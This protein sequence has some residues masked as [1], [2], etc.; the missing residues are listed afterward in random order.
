MGWMAICRCWLS[1][2]GGLTFSPLGGGPVL[3]LFFVVRR[4]RHDAVSSVKRT[5]GLQQHRVWSNTLAEPYRLMADGCSDSLI[6]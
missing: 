1:L 6:L 5:L 4:P 3:L 2:A